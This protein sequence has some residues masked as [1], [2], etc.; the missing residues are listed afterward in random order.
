M[1]L[2]IPNCELI[3]INLR[4]SE[5][6]KCHD[7]RRTKFKQTFEDLK[8]SNIELQNALE[9]KSKISKEIDNFFFKM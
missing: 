1:Q 3:W 4:D 9:S 8:N 2:L 6:F 7:I 5:E